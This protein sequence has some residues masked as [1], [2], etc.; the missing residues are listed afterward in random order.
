[1]FS[2]QAH[3]VL[4]WQIGGL[5]LVWEV[6]VGQIGVFFTLLVALWRIN[7]FHNRLMVEHEILVQDYCDRNGL[8]PNA[9]P[10]RAKNRLKIFGLD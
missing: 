1:M 3:P 10:T 9:M 4:F 6:S 2:H 7:T 5:K 8:D